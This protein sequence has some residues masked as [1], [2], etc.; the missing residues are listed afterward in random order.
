M[1][2]KPI[3]EIEKLNKMLIALPVQEIENRKANLAWVSPRTYSS[4][5]ELRELKPGIEI[6]FEEADLD[7]DGINLP[8]INYSRLGP[9]EF[10]IEISF[11]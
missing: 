1:P 3:E 11:D 5:V 10:K 2:I 4:R 7:S 9:N 6:L 8:K